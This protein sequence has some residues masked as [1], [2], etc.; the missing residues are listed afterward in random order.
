MFTNIIA[1]LPISYYLEERFGFWRI[2]PIFILSGIGG[3]FFS[4]LIESEC[5]VLSFILWNKYTMLDFIFVLAIW[6]ERER[7]RERERKKKEY[8]IV[9]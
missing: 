4:A 2:L 1:F 8:G 9:F 6:G 5:Q 7:E 3:N